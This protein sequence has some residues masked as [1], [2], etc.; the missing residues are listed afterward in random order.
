MDEPARLGFV[1]QTLS[2]L[3]WIVIAALV[4]LTMAWPVDGRTGLPVWSLILAFAGYNLLL[5]ATRRRVGRLRSFGLVPLLDLPV[6]TWLYSFDHGPNGPVFVLFFLAV[7]SAAAT[8]SVRQIALYTGAVAL[9][10]VAVVPAFPWWTRDVWSIRE[11]GTRIV[12]LA[13]VG[14]GTSL[15][16]RRLVVEQAAARSMRSRTARLEELDRLRSRF[17]STVSHDL[18]TPLTAAKAGL[19]MLELSAGER[20]ATD[21][22][23]LLTN[24]R[25]NVER[26][27]MHIDDLLA[28]NQLEAGAMELDHESIDLRTVAGDAFAAIQPLLQQKGQTLE[29]ELPEPLPVEGDGRRLEQVVVNVLANAHRHTPSGTSITISGRTADTVVELAVSDNGSGIP[30]EE[31]ERIFARFHRLHTVGEG[32]GLGL[33]IAKG[34]VEL[35]GGRMWAEDRPGQGATFRLAFPRRAV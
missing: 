31:L 27:G 35:H 12:V 10:A 14:V 20:L 17:V 24:V 32:S 4:F 23:T 16:T 1:G 19:G 26:L 3:R 25:R 11:L 21:E 15:L 29:L 28:F 6:A 2:R 13:L 5:E 8:M 18:R 9:A 22:R 34:I 30:R 33:A 7:I